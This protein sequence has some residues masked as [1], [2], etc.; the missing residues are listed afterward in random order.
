[1]KR[2]Y[3]HIKAQE[4]RIIELRNSGKTRQEIADELGLTRVQVKDRICRYN[5]CIVKDATIAPKERGR[6]PAITLA[7][8][9]YEVK[10]LKMENTLLRDFLWFAKKGCGQA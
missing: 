3:T 5:R 10:R 9:K 6:K 2:R 7:E 1:M 8:Y 4:N